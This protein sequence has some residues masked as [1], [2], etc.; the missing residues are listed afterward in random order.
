MMENEDSSSSDDVEILKLSDSE[1]T[2]NDSKTNKLTI[3]DILKGRRIANL[4]Q[5]M[6]LVEFAKSEGDD[7]LKNFYDEFHPTVKK[8]MPEGSFINKMNATSLSYVLCIFYEMLVQSVGKDV[9]TEAAKEILRIGLAAENCANR[10]NVNK[11][12]NMFSTHMVPSIPIAAICQSCGHSS[13]N[14]NITSADLAIE[15]QRRRAA[16]CDS[17]LTKKSNTR[18]K[19]FKEQQMILFCYCYTFQCHNQ[20]DGRSCIECSTIIKST[21]TTNNIKKACQ[22]EL[23]KC[24][25]NLSYK[26][27]DLSK[28]AR[29]SEM[30]KQNFATNKNGNNCVQE[31][32]E[33]FN[34]LQQQQQNPVS[35]TTQQQLRLELG[36]PSSYLESTG[37]HINSYTTVNANKGKRAFE[38]ALNEEKGFLENAKKTNI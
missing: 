33:N 14:S 30:R 26:L 23:C 6:N 12:M 2:L 1:I 19:P 38:N 5:K 8:T 37:E 28:V 18:D 21:L 4:N 13:I 24:V 11:H 3:R 7:F 22:C 35:Y 20:K 25:C 17:P 31:F 36:K 27:S 16:H 15:N 9:K 32:K 34:Q 10:E 29:E